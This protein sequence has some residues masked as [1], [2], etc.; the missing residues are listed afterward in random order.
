[1]V[2]LKDN[3]D[4]MCRDNGILLMKE[5]QSIQANAEGERNILVHE[6]SDYLHACSTLRALVMSLYKQKV[7]AVNRGVIPVHASLQCLRS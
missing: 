6:V 5:I 7:V 4:K 1:M 2:T 3:A